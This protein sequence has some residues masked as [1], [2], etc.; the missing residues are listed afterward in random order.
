MVEC[1]V[2]QQDGYF[3]VSAEIFDPWGISTSRGEI[4]GRS[5]SKV[6][7]ALLRTP[8]MWKPFRIHTGKRW[9]V[10]PIAPDAVSR[11]LSGSALIRWMNRAP[12][13]VTFSRANPR[14]VSVFLEFRTVGDLRMHFYVFFSSSSDS[15]NSRPKMPRD[16]TPVGDPVPI[17]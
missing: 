2:G 11:I 4:V 8:R 16:D 7:A 12:F 1:V 17:E 6:N 13:N 15:E 14:T 9:R 5:K 10:T 3:A